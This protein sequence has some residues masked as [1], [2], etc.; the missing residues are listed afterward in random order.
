[1]KNK[2]MTFLCAATTVTAAL[3]APA[4]GEKLK[5]AVA[6][7][8]S[9]RVA[10]IAIGDSNQRFGGHGYTVAMPKALATV[11]PI[12]ATDLLI[13]RQWKDKNGPEP[14]Q[15][16]EPLAKLSSHWYIASGETGKVSWHGGLLIVPADHLLDVHGPL[17]FHF[18]YG[19]FESGQT[20]F[21]PMV[22]RD[23]SPWTVLVKSQS[24]I[25]P[26]TGVFGLA[27]ITLDL[28]AD[29][30][31]SYPLQFM[32]QPINES[33][34]GPFF[35]AAAVAENTSRK[36]GLAYHTLY[37]VGGQS[38][39]EMLIALRER[40]PDRLQTYFTDVRALLNGKK[41]AIVMIHSGLNDRNRSMPSIGPRG[42]FA[43]SSPEGYVDNLEGLVQCLTSAWVA[44]GGT[45]ETL[46]FA[47]M[48]SHTLGDPDD[49]NLI[50]YRAAAR[51]LA[52]KLPSAS[53]I[54]LSA[55]VPYA[56]MTANHYY[57]KGRKTDAHLAPTGYAAI[58][59]A[60]ADELKK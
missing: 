19:T 57:D 39:R 30:S 17:R 29:T 4:V 48:P 31:R 35:A 49:A 58:A 50:A 10:V 13:Y 21:K 53:M 18:T 1:M 6:L 3:G 45:P 2:L 34:H 26:V 20:G 40:G 60:L 14:A 23:Q 37:G 44:T 16:P 55:L 7:A 36:N 41:T 59:G 43:S 46:H 9:E 12:Y 27:R 51:A 33:I 32:P 24:E 25:N 11:A 54:D 28:P 52:E 22:R 8:Q 47:F 42:D 38:L 15:A 56:E 5:A